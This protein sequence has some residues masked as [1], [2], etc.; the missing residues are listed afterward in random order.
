M[1]TGLSIK[2]IVLVKIITQVIHVKNTHDQVRW[3]EGSV[4]YQLKMVSWSFNNFKYTVQHKQ[5]RI[6]ANHNGQFSKGKTYILPLF[7]VNLKCRENS[8]NSRKIMSSIIEVFW[9]F[10]MLKFVRFG[11]NRISEIQFQN[12]NPNCAQTR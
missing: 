9:T 8:N 4:R 7:L 6:A 2:H 11:I 5:I 12:R 3:K 1:N 10:F